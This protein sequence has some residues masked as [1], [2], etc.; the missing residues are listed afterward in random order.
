MWG[1]GRED[2]PAYP[3]Y[4]SKKNDFIKERKIPNAFSL[5]LWRRKEKEVSPSF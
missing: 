5:Y 4:R 1:E 2:R 3:L